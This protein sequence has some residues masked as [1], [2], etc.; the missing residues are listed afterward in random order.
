[1]SAKLEQ[2]AGGALPHAGSNPELRSDRFLAI[3]GALYC[4][5]SI[6]RTANFGLGAADSFAGES[7][8]AASTSHNCGRLPPEGK[9]T[10]GQGSEPLARRRFQRGVLELRGESWTVRFR[11]DI[12][13]PDGAARRVE[14][15]RVV[16]TRAELP[17]KK[18]ARRRADEIVAHVN[19]FS[20][21][22]V[23][24]A[25][26]ADFSDV[27]KS[28]ALALMKPSTR[29]AAEAHLRVYLVPQFGKARLDEL[30]TGSAQAFVTAMAQ[31]GRSRHYVKNV[32]STFRSALRSAR[33]WGYLVGEF[34][35]ADLVLPADSIRKCPPF[36]TALQ[37][38]AIIDVACEPWH[39]VFA[40]AAM[41]GMRPG[42]VFGV[43]VDDLDFERRLIFVRQTAYYSKLQTPKTRSSIAPVPMPGPLEKML[44]EFLRTWKPN[45]ARLLF[46]TRNGTPFAENNIVQRKLWPIL[47]SLGIPRCGMHAFRH[48]HASLLVA[49]GA[50]PAVAQ[51]QLRHADVATTLG[52]YTHVLGD[53]QRVAAEKVAFQLRPDATKTIVSKSQ[54]TY[55]Q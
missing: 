48:T 36:F 52:I 39:T 46:A 33:S 22:P 21:R 45:A 55:V 44:R 10:N 8:S 19:G 28:R 27:W 17:T 32:L 9:R 31:R 47:D 18:L 37:A 13:Q 43:T 2:F 49:Q 6:L 16:G 23:R 25:T 1:M 3:I 29:K 54:V 11:E 24:V 42:E 50:T 35:F 40:V 12:L 20:Y 38:A 34:Q 41:T 5:L 30:N 14:V 53:D 7:E 26:F 4:L 51:R 15:R